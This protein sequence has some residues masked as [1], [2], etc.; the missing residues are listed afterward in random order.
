MKQPFSLISVLVLTFAVDFVVACIFFAF[1]YL[2]NDIETAASN[3]YGKPCKVYNSL[4]LV[5]GLFVPIQIA[6][7]FIGT[8]YIFK[9]FGFKFFRLLLIFLANTV[10]F[11]LIVVALFFFVFL[12][13]GSVGNVG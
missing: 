4:F 13:C 2:A 7:F 9:H 6:V 8:R 3:F 10:A 1:I 12:A 11:C 5:I